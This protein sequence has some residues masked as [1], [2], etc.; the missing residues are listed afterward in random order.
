MSMQDLEGKEIRIN[1]ELF[2]VKAS[3]TN[4]AA[5]EETLVLVK[6]IADIIPDEP[7]TIQD[8][9]FASSTN[10]NFPT[11]E[12][13][14]ALDFVDQRQGH[15]IEIAMI[16][17]SG[18]ISLH[19]IVLVG[20]SL[21]DPEFYRVRIDGDDKKMS[22]DFL[23]NAFLLAKKFEFAIMEHNKMKDDSSSES[24]TPEMDTKE[25]YDDLFE[26]A[27]KYQRSANDDPRSANTEVPD[28][29]E[30]IKDILSK[31]KSS[32]SLN[33]KRFDET[34]D[35]KGF[36]EAMDSIFKGVFGGKQFR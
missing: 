29:T 12:L 20:L 2:T 8:L 6:P 9:G 28:I 16:D 33:Q 14:A 4:S 19:E 13:D 11:E 31:V 32:D 22:I 34:M 18:L 3:F 27:M 5:G 21:K 25:I 1:G 23:I 7:R 24:D 35:L 15:N 17:P 10:V 36:D 26:G 30:V